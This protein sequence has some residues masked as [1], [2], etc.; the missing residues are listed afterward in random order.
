MR[1]CESDIF[2]KSDHLPQ[3]LVAKPQRTILWDAWRESAREWTVTF[4]HDS[5]YG[6][7]AM[8]VIGPELTWGL[9]D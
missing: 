4:E 9:P 5:E 6:G 3:T 1:T 7:K 2:I 8:R